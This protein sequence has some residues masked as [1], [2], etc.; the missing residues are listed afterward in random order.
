MTPSASR[1]QGFILGYILFALAVLAVTTIATSQMMGKQ[2]A[3]KWIASSKDKVEDQANVIMTQ[4]AACA[5]LNEVDSVDDY[6]AAYP[7]GTHALVSAL[8]CPGTSATVWDSG[9]GSYAPQKISGFSDWRYT[10]T[11][12]GSSITV[13]FYVTAQ[14]ANGKVVLSHA[15][16]RLGEGQVNLSQTTTANDTMVVHIFQ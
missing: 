8:I 12:A 11:V 13:Y 5:T 16:R 6:G 15:R 4:L 7:T 10:K 2:D 14:D 3:A 1:T 9:A